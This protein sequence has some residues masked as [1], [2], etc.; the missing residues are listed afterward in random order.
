MSAGIPRYLIENHGANSEAVKAMFAGA[1]QV[2]S[3]NGITNITLLVPTKQHFLFT[4]VGT[5]L[6]DRTAK[7]LRNGETVKME[8]NFTTN[9]TVNV[10]MNLESTKTFYP[11]SSYGMIIGVY[12]SRKDQ[13][14]LDSVSSARAIV[15]LPWTEDE[16]KAW[17]STWNPTIL[18]KSTWQAQQTAFPADVEKALLNLT[19]TINLTTGLSNP[20]DKETARQTLL[21]IKR[22][23]HA[24]DPDDIRKWALRNNWEPRHAEDFCRLASKIFG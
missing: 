23:G 21:G 6:G 18:G 15:F 3:Q 1:F 16:G 2:C 14:V 20:S 8:A 4:E 12:L 9:L 5:L 7:A 19:R 22:R 11:H 24:L 13:N 10:T 17:L